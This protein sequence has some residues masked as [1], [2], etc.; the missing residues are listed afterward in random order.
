GAAEPDRLVDLYETLER[1][2]FGQ[3]AV[4]YRTYLELRERT[5]RL[6]GVYAYELELASTSLRGPDGAERVFTGLITT[7]YFS[8]LGIKPAAG[9]L[10]SPRDSDE[11]GASPFAVLNHR[12]WT[13]RFNADPSIVG[14]TLQLNGQTFTVIGIAADGFSGTSV[15]APD[16]WTSVGN[17][18]IFRPTTKD[19]GGLQVAVS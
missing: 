7:N 14:T 17:A 4:A 2:G 13:R 15:V 1:G 10:L 19:A 3:P 9:R 11:P 8:L 16:I 12:F 6:E 5:T 18:S